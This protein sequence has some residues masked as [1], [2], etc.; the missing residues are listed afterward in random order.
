[1]YRVTFQISIQKTSIDLSKVS[2]R[3]VKKF[4]RSDIIDYKGQGDFTRKSEV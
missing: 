1:M 3:I 2:I 4:L